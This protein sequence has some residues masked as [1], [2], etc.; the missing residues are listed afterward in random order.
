MLKQVMAGTGDLGVLRLCRHLG[1]RTG[2]NPAVTYGSHLAVHMSLGL[3]FLGGGLATLSTTPEAVAAMLCAFFPRFPTHSND[4]RWLFSFY[5][6]LVN[7]YIFFT[8]N[9]N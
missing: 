5:L 2:S 1:G 6:L 8:G 7:K 3:L 9:N 4:N